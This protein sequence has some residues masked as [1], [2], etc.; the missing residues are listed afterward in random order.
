MQFEVI[1]IMKGNCKQ[2]A[3]EMG[4]LEKKILTCK[5][6]GEKITP[7]SVYEQIIGE[8]SYLCLRC[9]G[10]SFEKIISKK[11]IASLDYKK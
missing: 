8:D 9:S 11:P 2:Q 7:G 4:K 1:L 10:E 6:C 3:V 5:V